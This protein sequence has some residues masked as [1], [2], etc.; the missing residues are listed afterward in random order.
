MLG[1]KPPSR[2]KRPPQYGENP[3]PA[4][5]VFLVGVALVFGAYYLWQG[6]RDFVASGGLGVAEATQ[7]ITVL[8]TATAEQ[9]QAQ[10]QRLTPRVTWTPMPE[11]HDFIVIVPSAIVR[12]QPSTAAQIMES[13]PEGEPVCVIARAAEDADWYVIDRNPRTTRSIEEGYM[14]YNIIEAVNPT[15]TP[16]DTFTPA[17]TVTPIPIPSN[18]PTLPPTPSYTPDPNA[19]STPIPT[20]PGLPTAPVQGV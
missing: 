7:R 20:L 16:S 3:I 5:L 11:C 2:S 13:L 19:T 15:P 1:K 10:Q 18:T 14:F 9:I 6:I 12:A 8:D 4:W 17:P